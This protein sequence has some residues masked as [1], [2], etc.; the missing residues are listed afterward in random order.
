LSQVDSENLR[1][2]KVII[3]SV[4]E[5]SIEQLQTIANAEEIQL[6]NKLEISDNAYLF[7]SNVLLQRAF[8]NIIENAIKY[9]PKGTKVKIIAKKSQTA[10]DIIIS[11]LDEGEGIHGNDQEKVFRRFYRVDKSRTRETGGTGL[12]LAITKEI[13]ELHGCS[14]KIRSRKKQGTAVFIKI[15]TKSG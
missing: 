1:D 15:P 14:T 10:D 5:S 6:I 4:L 11:V 3:K 7:G 12:G 2:E 8:M 9:S 13:L